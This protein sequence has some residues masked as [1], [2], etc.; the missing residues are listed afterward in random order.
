MPN[1]NRV[2]RSLFRS[3]E[4]QECLTPTCSQGFEVPAVEVVGAVDGT[5][6]GF[7]AGNEGVEGVGAAGKK[8]P[9]ELNP[10][11][12][13]LTSADFQRQQ[14]VQDAQGAQGVQGASAARTQ[15]AN[16]AEAPY[17]GAFWQDSQDFSTRNAQSSAQTSPEQAPYD[18]A[19]EA[20]A[21]DRALSVSESNFQGAQ[22][23]PENERVEQ[24]AQAHAAEMESRRFAELA[25]E[26]FS[27]LGRQELRA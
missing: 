4:L 14:Q 16:Q 1:V 23:L 24:A 3:G 13:Q 18:L 10:A 5:A 2:K 6:D 15:Q 7:D 11:G 8:N 26:P 9:L 12:Q 20:A 27:L 19:A 25:Q 22:D 17:Q 21:D